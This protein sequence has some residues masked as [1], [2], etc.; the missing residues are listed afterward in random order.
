M[1]HITFT[2]DQAQLARQIRDDLAGLFESSPPLLIVLVSA[3][4]NQDPIVAAEIARARQSDVQLLPILTENVALPEPLVYEKPLNFA[5]GYRRASLLRRLSQSTMTRGEVRRANRRAL[6]VIG[7]I[8]ALMFGL[9]I[10]GILSGLVAFPVAEYNEEATFQSLWIDGLI[11][12]TLE[13]ARPR[14]TDDALNFAATLEAAPTRLYY[15][16]RGTATALPRTQGE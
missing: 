10:I 6:L 14:S 9:A 7:A 2:A 13:Y 11:R 1:I 15:Y 5:A 3:A 4:S 8:A 12:E 16:V